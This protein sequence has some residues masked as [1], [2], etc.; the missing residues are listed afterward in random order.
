M[1]CNSD[2]DILTSNYTTTQHQSIR[3][4]SNRFEDSANHSKRNIK[5]ATPAKPTTRVAQD[6]P[7]YQKRDLFKSQLKF[8]E[9][10]TGTNEP[11]EC[12]YNGKISS[13]LVQKKKKLARVSPTKKCTQVDEEE[14]IERIRQDHND[15]HPIQQSRIEAQEESE[16]YFEPYQEVKK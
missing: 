9:M 14:L 15:N 5:K 4:A 3:A 2:Q 7:N 16:S 8:Q 12:H 10:C 6:T 13:Y 11:T 1:W